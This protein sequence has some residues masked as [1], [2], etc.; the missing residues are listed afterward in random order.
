MGARLVEDSCLMLKKKRTI[1][2]IV[3]STMSYV[4]CSLSE[5]SCEDLNRRS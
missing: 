5:S 1:V 2:Y 4:F 3:L